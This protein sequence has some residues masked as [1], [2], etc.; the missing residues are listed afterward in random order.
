MLDIGAG[1]GKLLLSAKSDGW[2]VVGIETSPRF[3]GVA[4]K[5]SGVEVRRAPLE[6]CGFASD[7]FDVVIL[8]AVLEHL[9][10]PDEVMREVARVLRRGGILYVDVPN[11]EGLYFRM[12]NLY[13]KLRRGCPGL[14]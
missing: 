2:K 1:R 11:E 7:S 9:Y 8:G 13:E 14:C 10:N 5:Y 3:A 12:G 4:E 6:Q